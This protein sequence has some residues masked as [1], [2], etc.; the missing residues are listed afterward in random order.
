MKDLLNIENCF[1]CGENLFDVTPKEKTK[2]VYLDKIYTQE[3]PSESDID[4]KVSEDFKTEFLGYSEKEVELIVIPKIYL[5]QCKVKKN[6]KKI[7][8]GKFAGLFT[9]TLYGYDP[10]HFEMQKSNDKTSFV[11]IRTENYDVAINIYHKEFKEHYLKK[12]FAKYIKDHNWT[13]EKANEELENLFGKSCIVVTIP[14]VEKKIE[15]ICE[16]FDYDWILQKIDRY[17]MM[18]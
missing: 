17:I 16:T 11:S 15:M 6:Q 13:M 9:N 18:F 8:T 14:K 7:E 10:L 12:T 5:Y 4:K 3:D 2:D 1:I